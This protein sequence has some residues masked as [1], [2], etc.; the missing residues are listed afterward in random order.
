MKTQREVFNKLFKEEKTELS[1]QKIELAMPNLTGYSQKAQGAYNDA[2]KNARGV[3]SRAADEMFSARKK[4]SDIV[5]DLS[6]QFVKVSK[7]AE[8]L[9]VDIN[10][11][12]VGKN[13]AKVS[14][15]LEDYSISALELQR[16]IQKFNI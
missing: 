3:I 6:K 4:I 16:K 5:K 2:K 14:K 13:F 10:N 1:A 8:D 9:G 12:K 15:E 11:T 7:Q